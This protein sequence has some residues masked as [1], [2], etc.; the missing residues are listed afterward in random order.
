MDLLPCG[1][2]RNFVSFLGHVF[3]NHHLA[4]AGGMGAAQ[5]K[6]HMMSLLVGSVLWTG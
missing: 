5:E 2:T 3:R 1:P 4:G 6:A